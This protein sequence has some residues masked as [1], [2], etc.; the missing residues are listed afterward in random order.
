MQTPVMQTPV[1]YRTVPSPIGP[2][3]LAGVGSTLTHLRMPGQ[4]H[5]SDRSVW[6]PAAAQAFTDVADQLAAYFAGALR[7]FDVDLQ[8]A[9]TPF[10]QRVW[11][12]LRTIPY[13]ETRSYGQIAAQIGIPAAARAVGLANARNPIA[14][15]VPCH[16]VIG[17]GGRL[18]GYAGG[19]DRKRDLLALEAPSPDQEDGRDRHGDHTR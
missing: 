1:Q 3:T 7:E 10:Q 9:G 4:T 16:R 18:T 14:I 6:R 5:E 15:I 13:G 11:A 8:L 12:A 17:S 19:L 2:L